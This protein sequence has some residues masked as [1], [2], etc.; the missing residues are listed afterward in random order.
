MDCGN[1]ILSQ[2]NKCMVPYVVFDE[3]DTKTTRS[4]I[5]KRSYKILLTVKNICNYS[6]EPWF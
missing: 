5:P 2:N 3:F 6:V 4:K 1:I